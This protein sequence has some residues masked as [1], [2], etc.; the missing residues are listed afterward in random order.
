VEEGQGVVKVLFLLVDSTFYLQLRPRLRIGWRVDP[1]SV[2][3][4]E[5]MTWIV[6]DNSRC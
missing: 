3:G 1:P 6:A 5:H 4:T 2:E